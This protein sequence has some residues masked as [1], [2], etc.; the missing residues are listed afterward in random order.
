MAESMALETRREIPTANRCWK[1]EEDELLRK[2]VAKYGPGKWA[3]AAQSVPGRTNH[4]LRQRWMFYLDPSI[5]KQPLTDHEYMT[6]LTEQ[7]RI[8]NKWMDIASL[9]PGR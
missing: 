6:I 1:P 8:G 2:A 3:L 4:Q 9:L 7:F 5:N